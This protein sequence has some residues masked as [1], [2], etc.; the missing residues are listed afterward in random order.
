MPALSK[1]RY[2]SYRQCPKL[3][4]LNTYAEERPE[5]DL[6]T[7]QRMQTGQE[8]GELAKG[9]FGPRCHDPAHRKSDCRRSVSD[10]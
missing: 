7:L 6:A 2:V 1:S 5:I 9:L 4:W 8:V 10:L 3:L